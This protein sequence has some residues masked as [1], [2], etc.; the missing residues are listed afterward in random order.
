MG[1]VA[2][3]VMQNKL[4]NDLFQFLVGY[5]GVSNLVILI[6]LGGFIVQLGIMLG[7]PEPASLVRADIP[8][9]LV[10]RDHRHTYIH[11]FTAGDDALVHMQEFIGSPLYL[12]ILCPSGVYPLG[13]CN[14]FLQET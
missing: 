4:V 8:F 1:A 7:T 14:N 12:L 13:L 3:V 5:S 11:F 2:D 10:P 9:L 6:G